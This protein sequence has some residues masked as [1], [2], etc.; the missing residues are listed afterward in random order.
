MLSGVAVA[1]GAAGA[2]EDAGTVSGAVTDTDADED[3]DPRGVTP[4]GERP[5]GEACI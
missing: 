2:G 4:T 3:G 1:Y 5:P